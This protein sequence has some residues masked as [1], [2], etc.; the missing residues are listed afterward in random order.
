MSTKKLIL[1]GLTL[2][3]AT[4]G[5]VGAGLFGDDIVDT[6]DKTLGL[7][8]ATATEVS[9]TPEKTAET[10]KIKVTPLVEAKPSTETTLPEVSAST[11]EPVILP[12]PIVEVTQT[13]ESTPT[14]EVTQ[15][16]EQVVQLTF[17][18]NPTSVQ[19]YVAEPVFVTP[20]EPKE[21]VETP[22]ATL[23]E[24]PVETPVEKPTEEPTEELKEE[25]VDKVEEARPTENVATLTVENPVEE[26]PSETTEEYQPEHTL[27]ADSQSI[28]ET[29]PVAETELVAETPTLDSVV[30]TQPQLDTLTTQGYQPAYNYAG[31]N[32]Y[33]TGQ[34]TWGVK[35]VAPWVGNYWGNGAQWASS[36]QRDGFRTGSTPQVGAIASWNDGGYGHV[37]VVTHVDPSTGY[38]RVL[39]ANVNGDQTIRD[40]RGWFDPTI[41]QGTVT[42]IYNN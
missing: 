27:V 9:K 11:T 21:V 31:A 28:T 42:Y 1:S 38:I 40:H 5:A 3:T 29:K 17:K 13:V 8:K 30:E 20:E 19:P 18:E 24:E 37:A 15:P 32:S 41:A 10:S 33:P 39:E 16:S 6:L 34:C 4:L 35:V 22:N 14:I 2:S 12:T 23:A 25:P 26:T 7:K 36:A